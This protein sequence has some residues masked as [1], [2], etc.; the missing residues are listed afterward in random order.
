MGKLSRIPISACRR[1]DVEDAIPYRRI[2][3]KFPQKN[4]EEPMKQSLFTIV[5]NTALTDVF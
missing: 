1:R 4:K 2:S 3:Q 5:S